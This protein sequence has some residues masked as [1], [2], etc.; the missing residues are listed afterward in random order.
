M[1]IN[2]SKTY[3]FHAKFNFR[4][5]KVDFFTENAMIFA[6]GRKYKNMEKSK[7]LMF[8]AKNIKA[9]MFYVIFFRLKAFM[10]L[11][12]LK[13]NHQSLCF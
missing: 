5:G 2:F 6:K 4:V 7:P 12:V 1:T 8:L 9:F 13:K 10:F 3:K 11:N